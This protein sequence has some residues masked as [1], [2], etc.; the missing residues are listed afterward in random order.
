MGSDCP[1]IK[2]RQVL[3][4]IFNLFIWP[5]AAHVSFYYGL[6]GILQAPSGKSPA[7]RVKVY[8]ISQLLLLLTWVFLSIIHSGSQNGWTKFP[9]FE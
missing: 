9:V 3:Y 6:Y 8:K 7:S 1:L 5:T 2:G 4:S